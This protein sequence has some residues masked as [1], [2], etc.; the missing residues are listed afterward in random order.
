M[1]EPRFE[2]GGRSPF[3]CTQCDS[4]YGFQYK[5]YGSLAYN[6]LKELDD[7]HYS[8]KYLI[9]SESHPLLLVETMTG[10]Q[11]KEPCLLLV[12]IQS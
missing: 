3:L 1:R 8:K 9:E 2:V 6:H 12:K 4:T 10:I 11:R 7:S 5:R